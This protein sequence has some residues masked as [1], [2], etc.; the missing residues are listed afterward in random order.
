MAECVNNA[1]WKADANAHI[2]GDNYLENGSYL[3]LST[4]TLGYTFDKL[5]EWAQS[6]QLYA[7]CNNVFTVT[8]YSGIDPEVSLGGLTPG[9]DY[10]ESAYPHTRS[11][12]IGAKINF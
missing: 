5:G 4:L 1:T 3:R 11:F 12:I 7:T 6:L 10:R 2:P 9:I 8:G